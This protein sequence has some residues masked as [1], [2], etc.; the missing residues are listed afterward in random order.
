MSSKLEA[1]IQTQQLILDS[2]LRDKHFKT[3]TKTGILYH[4]GSY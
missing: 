2:N 1:S 4:D 3:E